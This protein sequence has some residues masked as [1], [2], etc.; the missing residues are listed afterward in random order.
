MK[1]QEIFVPFPDYHGSMSGTTKNFLDYFW[2]KF[3]GKTFGYICTSHE[4][5][6]TAMDQRRTAVR[7]CMAGVCMPYRVSINGEQDLT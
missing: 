5:G 4:K 3:A 6:L 7:Q 1:L 2:E